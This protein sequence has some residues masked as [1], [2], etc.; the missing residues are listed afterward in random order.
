MKKIRI[1][2]VLFM[3]LM[4]GIIMTSCGSS[5]RTKKEKQNIVLQ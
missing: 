1:Y 5:N 3:S 4:A 2:S